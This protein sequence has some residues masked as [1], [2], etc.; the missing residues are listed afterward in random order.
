MC[1][2]AKTVG[3]HPAQHVRSPGANRQH[4]QDRGAGLCETDLKQRDRVVPTKDRS[5]RLKFYLRAK[6]RRQL[7]GECGTLFEST[8][9]DAKCA[10]R[11][12]GMGAG[13][14]AGHAQL[15]TTARGA[16]VCPAH[17]R[18]KAAAVIRCE[19][20]KAAAARNS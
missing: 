5:R 6:H 9:A 8:A 4:E 14:R 3:S 18:L 1:A 11:G 20:L 7:E 19:G 15:G 10:G 16:W 17:R 2:R 13:A 12:D